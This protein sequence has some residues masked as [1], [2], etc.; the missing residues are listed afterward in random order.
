MA[1]IACTLYSSRSMDPPL[2]QSSPPRRSPVQTSFT[3]VHIGFIA[4]TVLNARQ[5]GVADRTLGIFA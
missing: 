5:F 1:E 2:R 3:E 4:N